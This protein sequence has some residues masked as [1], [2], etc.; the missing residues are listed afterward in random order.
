MPWSEGGA[1]ECLT[2]LKECLTDLKRRV[3][4]L[5]PAATTPY[6]H[7][8]QGNLV[9]PAQHTTLTGKT[10]RV[11]RIMVYTFTLMPMVDRMI[12]DVALPAHQKVCEQVRDIR[13]AQVARRLQDEAQKVTYAEYKA[14]PQAVLY[15]ELSHE[16]EIEYQAY[17]A[18]ICLQQAVLEEELA[19]KQAVCDALAAAARAVNRQVLREQE[20][21]RAN[22]AKE[23]MIALQYTKSLPTEVFVAD[24]TGEN[25]MKE[26]MCTEEKSWAIKA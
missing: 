9:D 5:I 20:E 24:I 22:K 11:T 1:R 6:M 3:D 18:T 12:A 2:D 7:Q 21:S 15:N 13:K 8:L 10:F 14:K 19:K 23:A 25:F 17:Q 16:E 4:L 26:I